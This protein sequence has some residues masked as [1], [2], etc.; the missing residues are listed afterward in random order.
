MRDHGRGALRT[1][2]RTIA[3]AAAVAGLAACTMP[4]P[5]ASLRHVE[6]SSEQGQITLIPLTAATLP[7]P[8][9]TAAAGFPPEFM[10]AGDFDY[11]TLGP[12]DRLAVRI[13]ENTIPGVPGL[14][15]ATG[16]LAD[17]GEVVVD[18]TGRI[19]LP[20]AGSIRVTGL[21]VP[22]VRAEALRRLRTVIASPQVD[23]RPVETRSRLVSVQGAAAKGGTYPIERGRTRLGQLLA[24]VAPEQENPEMLAVTVRRGSQAG[25]VRLSDVYSRPELD[26]PLQPGDSVILSEVVENL[27]VLGATGEQ[28]VL[29]IP[30][31]GFTLIEALGQ[32]K[33]LSPE[34]ADPRAVFVLRLPPDPAAPPLVYQVD[35]RRPESIALASRFV[36]RP[37]DAVLVSNAPFAQTRLM[38]MSVAQ[39]LAS[40]RNAALVVP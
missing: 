22:Q 36:V 10:Q 5:V 37:N 19:Y 9:A 35:M 12:G 14:F 7:P 24:D 34:M 18:E 21:S 20:Y 16:G 27:T 26:I 1:C 4:A 13:W 2:A 28:G 29:Q 40:V 3:A 39:G 6:A 8:T 17:V 11:D 23:I 32:A 30:K 15:T 33:G 38:L 25:T 31:R